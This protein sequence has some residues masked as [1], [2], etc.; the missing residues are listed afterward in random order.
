MDAPALW[1]MLLLY[2]GVQLQEVAFNSSLSY[3]PGWTHHLFYN[4]QHL[5]ISN[6]HHQR[7]RP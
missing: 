4:A 5:I 3:L 6:N 1:A 2:L 7:T